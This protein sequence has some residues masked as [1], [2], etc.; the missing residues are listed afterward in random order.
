MTARFA[1]TRIL[2]DINASNEPTHLALAHVKAVRQHLLD[3]L[4]DDAGDRE[5][6]RELI[7]AAMSHAND[8]VRDLNTLLGR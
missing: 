7:D 3:L 6:E 8:L 5:N 4:A 2:A 1:H